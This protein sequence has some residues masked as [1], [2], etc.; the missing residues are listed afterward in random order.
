MKTLA[1][2]TINIL[3]AALLVVLVAVAIAEPVSAQGLTPPPETTSDFKCEGNNTQD[4]IDKNPI[5]K[6]LQFFMNVISVVIVAGSA[7]MIAVGGLQYTAARDNPQAVQAAKQKIINV[8]IGLLSYFFLYA[9]LQW[10]VP[11]GIF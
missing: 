11:G 5:T 3:C 6:W 9:F 2:T 4:C 10:L 7:I 8:F 1:I